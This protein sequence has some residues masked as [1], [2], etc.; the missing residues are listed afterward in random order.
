MTIAASYENSA[1]I[2]T[3]EYSLPNNSTSLTPITVDG[4]YQIFIDCTNLVAGDEYLLKVYEK[5]T[6]GGTQRC[7]MSCY[8]VGPYPEHFVSASYIFLHGWDVTLK[9]TAGSDRTIYWSIRSVA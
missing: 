9:R 2:S 7:I 3:T 1:S 8:L 5:I 4:I 6:S